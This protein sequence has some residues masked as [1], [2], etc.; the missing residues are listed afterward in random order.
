MI[1]TSASLHEKVR[2]ALAQEIQDGHYDLTGRIP[3]E[4]ELCE[5][6]GVSRITVRRAV[7]DLEELGVVRRRQGAGTFILKRAEVL[8]S[9]S[10]GG[11]ADKL[12]DTGGVKSRI[13]KSA[14]TLPADQEVA[15]SLGI[16]LGDPVFVLERVFVLDEAALSLDRSIY[17]LRRY[18]GFAE[19]VTQDTSTYQVLRS[20]YGVHFAE[21]RREMSI[22]YTTAE[23]ATWLQRPEHEPLL[24]INKIALDRDGRVIHTARIESVP[25]RVTLR[26]VAYEDDSE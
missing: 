7:S 23:T 18:P 2:A 19:K 8:G 26:T 4:P 17:P 3:P 24:V 22:G 15:A 21:V 14:E 9:M 5:R 6:F 1:R 13:V 16:S 10:I 11:F 20:D 12:S 25:S